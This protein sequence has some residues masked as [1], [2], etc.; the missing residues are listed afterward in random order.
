MESK[1]DFNFSEEEKRDFATR[2]LEPYVHYPN[3]QVPYVYTQIE[4]ETL[5]SDW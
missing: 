5:L 3:G 2:L 1:N 4:I